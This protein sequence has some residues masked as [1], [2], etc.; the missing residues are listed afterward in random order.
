WARLAGELGGFRVISYDRRGHG[1][2]GG[3]HET[4]AGDVEDLAELIDETG[5]PVHVVGGSFG[6]S[7]A[8]RLAAQRPD[9]VQSLSAHEPALPGLLDGAPRGGGGSANEAIDPQAFAESSLGSGAWDWLSEDERDGFRDNGDAYRDE[10]ADTEAFSIDLTSLAAFDRPAMISLGT[11]SPPFFRAIAEALAGVLPRAEIRAIQG[12]G[13][14][15][16]LTHA[17]EYAELVRTFASA[18]AAR[19]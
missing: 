6:A 10:M 8:L 1:R 2:S 13:H 16:H 5:A 11:E 12:A 15:P 17:R 9:L 7:V 3:R 14:L 4:I 18:A 19:R